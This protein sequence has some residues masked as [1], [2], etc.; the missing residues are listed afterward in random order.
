MATVLWNRSQ[1]HDFSAGW[2][3][4]AGRSHRGPPGNGLL[5]V[6]LLTLVGGTSRSELVSSLDRIH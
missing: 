1:A 2:M 3:T 6:T 5:R 4:A